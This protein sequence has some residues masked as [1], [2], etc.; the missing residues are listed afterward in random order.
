MSGLKPT[1]S[2][3]FEGYGNGQFS[4]WVL[5]KYKWGTLPPHQPQERELCN[6]WSS[7]RRKNMAFVAFQVLTAVCTK[8]A[9]FWVVTPCSLVEVYQRFRGP[10]CLH[11]QGDGGSKGLWNVGELLP[12]RMML[13]P[14]R[15]PSSNMTFYPTKRPALEPG[16]RDEGVTVLVC[17][18]P[19]IKS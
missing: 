13:Q 2:R 1:S 14:R 17:S 11:H 19:N 15:Q 3:C 16:S 10:C 9:V 12:D 18:R 4:N 6:L 8:M 5:P 7:S